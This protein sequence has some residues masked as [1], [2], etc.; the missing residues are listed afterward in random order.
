MLIFRYLMVN[1][2]VLVAMLHHEGAVFHFVD[3]VGDLLHCVAV[4]DHNDRLGGAQT[5]YTQRERKREEMG[6]ER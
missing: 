6:K 1:V 4:R 5:E 3:L 2:L